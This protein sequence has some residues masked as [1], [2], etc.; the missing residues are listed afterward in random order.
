L[1][2]TRLSLAVV[3]LLALVGA[4]QA[5]ATKPAN[6]PFFP[7]AGNEGYDALHY[8]VRLT[9]KPKG[10]RIKAR[11]EVEAVATEAL[12]SF[13]FDFLGPKVEEVKVDG[14]PA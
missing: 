11:T 5:L 8:E 10:G 12:K 1:R 3:G 13:S 14:E 2:Y 6:E 4:A 9:Y 7:S